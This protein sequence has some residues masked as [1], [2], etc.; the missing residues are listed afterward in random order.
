M[1]EYTL[2]EWLSEG[3]KRF[4]EDK[5][6]WK[7][8]CPMCGHIASIEDFKNEGSTNPNDAY[9]NC[10]GR[11]TGKG[12]P[13]KGDSSGCNRAAY[14]LFGIPKGGIKVNGQHIFD[15]AEVDK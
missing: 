11:F 12:S 9:L 2:K 4:G 5:L 6:K 15:F 3:E 1:K 13:K 14:G 10:I 7:F 8:K